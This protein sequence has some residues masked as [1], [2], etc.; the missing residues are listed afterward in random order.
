VPHV[1]LAFAITALFL[2]IIAQFYP[3]MS[4]EMNGLSNSAH[5]ASGIVG[6]ADHD[7]SFL[8][9]LVLGVAIAAPLWRILAVTYVLGCLYLRYPSP[10]LTRI[11][12]SSERLRAWA[13][14]DVFLLGALVALTK[15]HNLAQIDIGIGF[16]GLALVVLALA[17][18][19]VTFDRRAIWDMLSPP[20]LLEGMPPDR[21]GWISCHTCELLQKIS[22]PHTSY[23]CSCTRCGAA[24]HTRK[25]NSLSRTWALV[26]AGLILYI[27]A[28]IYPVLTI[29]SFGRGDPSTI[30]GGV[31][32]LFNGNDWPL[33]LIVFTASIVFPLLKLLGLIY[34]MVSVQQRSRL[35]L[36]DRTHL[37]RIIEFVGRWSI[38]DI[39]VA[40]LL[41]ALVTLGNIATVYPGNGAF[42]FG[43]VVVLTMLASESFDPRLIWDAAEENNG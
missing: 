16:W 25:P 38:I 7:F 40:A 8:A 42:A 22:K 36:A 18:L 5:I 6:L 15:L 29:I 3:I 11:F 19:D 31:I 32:E 12:R 13:M 17:A 30:M 9:I 43:A 1:A 21:N 33:A 27:P 24:L 35:C 4:I 39:F 20:V 14:L 26:I 34:L 10:Y 37:Y 41:T 23:N 2:Y 28:N